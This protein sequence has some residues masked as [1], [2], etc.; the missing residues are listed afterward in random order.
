DKFEQR[1][2]LDTG[3]G[4]RTRY[5]YNANNRRLDNL[6][7]N[8][9]QGYVFQNLNYGYDNVGNV[10]S[11]VNNTVAPSS[12]DVGMQAGGPSSQHFGY[13][14][15]YQL[16]H[17][18]G[19]YQPRTPRTDRYTVDL[20]YDSIH[21]ITNKNQVHEL[22]SNGNAIVDDKTSYNNGYAYGGSQPH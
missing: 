17:A 15:L 2:L 6:T 14:D 12:P 21:N 10:T 5:T 9:A 1:V 19:T 20:A 16:T 22:V 7:A 11:I 8:I 13:D 3:N 4:T 18:D